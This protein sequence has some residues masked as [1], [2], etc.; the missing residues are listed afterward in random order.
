MAAGRAG[1]AFGGKLDCCGWAEDDKPVVEGGGATS[2]EKSTETATPSSGSGD[3]V[4]SAASVIAPVVADSAGE[5]AGTEEDFF[6]QY[7]E[8]ATADGC[9]DGYF[10]FVLR[11]C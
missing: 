6:A 3:G 1:S 4:G 10:G 5:K 7:F 9:S 8:P 2:E 11:C